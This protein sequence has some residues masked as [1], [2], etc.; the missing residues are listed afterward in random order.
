MAFGVDVYN[1]CEPC[2]CLT[3]LYILKERVLTR[4]NISIVMCRIFVRPTSL[5]PTSRLLILDGNIKEK[6]EEIVLQYK[7]TLTLAVLA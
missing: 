5:V 1:K 3:M 6:V 2:E 7:H 4:D